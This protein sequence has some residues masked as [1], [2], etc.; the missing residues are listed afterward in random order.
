MAIHHQYNHT[1]SVHHQIGNKRN[2][3]NVHQDVMNHDGIMRFM[4]SLKLPS[5]SESITTRSEL[6]SKSLYLP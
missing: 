3:Q 1:Q 5:I 2:S 6:R 4:H